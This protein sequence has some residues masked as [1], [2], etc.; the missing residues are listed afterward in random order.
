MNYQSQ[1]NRLRTR[2]RAEEKILVAE[3]NERRAHG[4]IGRAAIKHY[5]EYMRAHGLTHLIVNEI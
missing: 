2:L 3:L 5:N 1:L 4:L